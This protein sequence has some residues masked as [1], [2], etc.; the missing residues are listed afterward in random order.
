[1]ADGSQVHAN[2]Q[3]FSLG[4]RASFDERSWAAVSR[5]THLERAV[6][7]HEHVPGIIII[8]VH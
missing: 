5:L 7:M 3:N 6:V 8:L 2:L 4:R 1:M